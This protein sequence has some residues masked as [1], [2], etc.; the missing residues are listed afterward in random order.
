MATGLYPYPD[1]LPDDVLQVFIDLLRGQGKMDRKTLHYAWHVAS[2]GF[3]RILPDEVSVAK[4]TPMTREQ[5]ADV[6]ES[7]KAGGPAKAL[8]IPWDVVIPIILQMLLS[9]F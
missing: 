4:T 6:L 8:P 9:A 2:F 7:L 1:Y 5:V 3:G